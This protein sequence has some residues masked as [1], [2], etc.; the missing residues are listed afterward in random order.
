MSLRTFLLLVSL[1]GVIFYG[2]VDH[3]Y[4]PAD[5]KSW[6][7]SVS[8]SIEG[9]SAKSHVTPAKEGS[10]NPPPVAPQ[11]PSSQPAAPLPRLEEESPAKDIVPAI[12]HGG[13]LRT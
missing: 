10:L 8:F 7:P 1:V 6:P 11:L 4:V 3:R 5:F 13:L 12:V 2:V 9:S